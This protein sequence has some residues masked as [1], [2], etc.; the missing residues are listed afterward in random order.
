MELLEYELD[1]LIKKLKDSERFR[2][3][4]DDIQN[5]YPFNRYE[6]IITKLVEE[7]VLSYE[8]YLELRNEYINRNLFLYVFE[9]S[10]P[11]G[12]GDTWGF[13]HLLSVEPELKRPS[14]KTDSAYKGQYDLY[15]PYMG[16]NIRIEVKGSR[17]VD[18]N[19]PNEPL[20]MKALSS[21]SKKDFLMNFQQ[22]KPTCCDVML[23]FAV[24]RDC[25]KYWVLKNTDI[26]N[27]NFS[28]QHRNS[29]TATRN[30]NYKKTDIYEGQVMI[31]RENI[32]TIEKFQV[33]GRALRQAI[34]E[35]F[36]E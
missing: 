13:S 27:L 12:F 9:I 24:Y 19:K 18:R 33:E 7:D 28:P 16:N 17:A 6:Y 14:R 36:E 23:W 4:I 25:V 11:R 2:S 26:Y 29:E 20:Y 35:K 30:E 5:I 21:N 10:A 8:D 3:E 15:L 32:S 22:V 31:T 34:I 1:S